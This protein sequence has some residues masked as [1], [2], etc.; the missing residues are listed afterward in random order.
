MAKTTG[1]CRDCGTH[2][3]PRDGEGA[4]NGL[5][6]AYDEIDRLR[7]LVRDA[8]TLIARHSWTARDR[9]TID[10]IHAAARGTAE[11]SRCPHGEPIGECNACDSSS[12]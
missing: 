2:L 11:P 8:S 3:P 7:A 12:A 4:C 9:P 1:F 10:R 5:R 6:Q